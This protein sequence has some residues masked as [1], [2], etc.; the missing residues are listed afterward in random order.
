ME[1]NMG[2]CVF[3]QWKAKLEY[4]PGDLEDI[5][6]AANDGTKDLE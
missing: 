3:R 6:L 2:T 1:V 4:K 5:L